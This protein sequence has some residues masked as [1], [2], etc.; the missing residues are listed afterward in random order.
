M[1]DVITK[2][3]FFSFYALYYELRETELP[4]FCFDFQSAFDF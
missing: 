2:Y 3:D 1:H 4:A